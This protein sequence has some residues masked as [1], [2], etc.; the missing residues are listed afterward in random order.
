VHGKAEKGLEIFT[1][2]VVDVD[3]NTA[4]HLST[5][6]T[7]ASAQPSETRVDQYLSHWQQ[8]YTALP[9]SIH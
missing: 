4:Y 3:Y 1:L 5:R 2:A 6:Q 7:A 9:P 8:D